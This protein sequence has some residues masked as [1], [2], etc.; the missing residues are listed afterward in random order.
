MPRAGAGAARA[1]ALNVYRSSI[2]GRARFAA[3]VT[4]GPSDSVTVRVT[5]TGP[6]RAADTVPVAHWPG[7]PLPVAAASVSIMI[8]AAAQPE[9]SDISASDSVI[10]ILSGHRD[11]DRGCDWHPVPA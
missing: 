4:Q 2:A 5:A 10:M 7:R 3:A 8:G 11:R 9:D 6:G 1:V